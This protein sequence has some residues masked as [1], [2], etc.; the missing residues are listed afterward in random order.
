MGHDFA[1]G[2]AGP[3]GSP[4]LPPAAQSA[5]ASVSI[6]VLG[7]PGCGAPALAQ[8]LHACLIPRMVQLH[9]AEPPAG[10][11]APWAL[12]FSQ[13]PALALLMGLDAPPSP[14]GDQ[15]AREQ[16]DAR[17]RALLGACGMGYQ[18]VYGRTSAQ[19]LRH[20]L[21]AIDKIAPKAIAS[22]ARGH[23]DLVSS[24]QSSR[25][26]STATPCEKCCDPVCE[27][28]LFTALLGEH[29]SVLPRP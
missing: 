16:A 11:G 18:V 3:H 21:I 2:P 13:P 5:T 9:C 10:S 20:A 8:A 7:V 1:E 6:A 27:H 17:L 12:P 19:R 25:S 22:S 24:G 15:A 29:A 28:R 26:R 14:S 4:L 23:F